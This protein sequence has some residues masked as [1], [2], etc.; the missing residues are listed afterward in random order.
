MTADVKTAAQSERAPIKALSL[1]DSGV[2]VTGGTSGVGLATAHALVQAG[3]RRIVL[4]GRNEERGLAARDAVRA[5]AASGSGSRSGTGGDLVIEFVAADANVAERATWAAENAIRLLG[6]VDVLVNSTVGPFVPGLFHN[7]SIDDILPA[8]VQQV[9]AP[10]HMCRALLP[11]MRARRTGSIINIASDAAKVP[12]P[13]EAVIGGAM[14]AIVRFSNT[15][16]MEAKRDGVRVNT[17]TPSLIGNTGSY[18]RVMS[19]EFSAK[20]FS[21]AVQAAHLGLVQPEDLAALIVFLAG[22][23]SARL[24][25]Q[26]ISVN[27]GISA[28]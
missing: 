19:S 27:G 22:P 28:A 1:G 11:G 21:K 9:A 2:V 20:L 4:I 12:T 14:A 25:G 24:T 8:I 18:D 5:G 3:V 17:V 13:G 16:A 6:N 10:L 23:E 26:T 7:M 15:L